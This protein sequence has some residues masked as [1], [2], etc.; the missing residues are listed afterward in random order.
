MKKRSL[1]QV[2]KK[3]IEAAAELFTSLWSGYEE[4]LNTVSPHR[5]RTSVNKLAG[6]AQFLGMATEKGNP[7]AT[8][9][10]TVKAWQK[11]VGVL[12]DADVMREWV[13]R[14]RVLAGPESDAAAKALVGTLLERRARQLET[15]RVD[16]RGLPGAETRIALQMLLGDFGRALSV[17][18]AQEEGFD[19]RGP[20]ASVATPWSDALTILRANQDDVLLHAFRVKNK[21]L[22]FVLE[23]LGTTADEDA[24]GERIRECAKVAAAT[25]TAL[26]NL[27]DLH[28]LRSTLRLERARWGEQGVGLEQ[29]AAALESARARLECEN[30]AAW[31]ECWPRIADPA[32]L[33]AIFNPPAES[34]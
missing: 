6:F 22:R 13:E 28:V 10:R 26:G 17:L 1:H 8:P 23:L 14:C 4:P 25:H 11:K 31:Y 29:S 18:K 9:F 20:L 12:R 34:R 30:F 16:A 7:A 15:V 32:F 3:E 5:Q 24:Q 33:G 27:S 2:M 21:R 19:F